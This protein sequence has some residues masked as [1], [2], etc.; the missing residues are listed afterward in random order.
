MIV[1]NIMLYLLFVIIL[2]RR[3][4]EKSALSPSFDVLRVEGQ[5]IQAKTIDTIAQSGRIRSVVK[6]VTQ[7]SVAVTAN[8][9]HANH[10]VG[11]VSSSYNVGLITI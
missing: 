2:N 9:L 6:D 1:V 5:K 7:M 11:S 8:H 3:R 4:N 10:A